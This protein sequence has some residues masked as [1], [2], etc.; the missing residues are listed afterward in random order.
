MDRSVAAYARPLRLPA[1]HLREGGGDG[2][3]NERVRERDDIGVGHPV[4][5]SVQRH[6]DA[7]AHVRVDARDQGI[8]HD[9]RLLKTDDV[10]LA[11]PRLVLDSQLDLSGGVQEG[12]SSRLRPLRG[13]LVAA[14]LIVTD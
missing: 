6:G 13:R 9:S 7:V 4:E 14:P 2:P 10:S 12:P 8:S 3:G 11:L 1:H 5:G